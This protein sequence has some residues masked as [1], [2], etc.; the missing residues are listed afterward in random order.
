MAE[1]T[2]KKARKKKASKD[3]KSYMRIDLMPGDQDL[4]AYVI[5]Q[6]ALE[7]ARLGKKISA[8]AYIQNLIIE[9]A[10][11]NKFDRRSELAKLLKDVPDRNLGTIEAVIKAFTRKA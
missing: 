10:N 1:E 11:K 2:K 5:K 3:S 8:T 6:A 9:D 4:K 7:T